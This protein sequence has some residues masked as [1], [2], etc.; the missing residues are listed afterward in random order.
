LSIQTI[1][2]FEIND[3]VDENLGITTELEITSQTA[4]FFNQILSFLAYGGSS[5]V[6]T[7]DQNYFLMRLIVRVEVKVSASVCVGFLYI[8]V[9][10]VASS[11]TT[12]ISRKESHCLTLFPE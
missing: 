8:F 7:L 9:A 2:A 12:N 6:K 11:L 3:R 5:T 4:D 1:A 10:S